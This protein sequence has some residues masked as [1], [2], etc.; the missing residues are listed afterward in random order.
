M[1][2]PT[3]SATIFLQQLGR[4][5]RQSRNKDVLTVLD[6]VGHQGKEFR[7]DLRYRRLLGRTRLELE[8]DI[9]EEFPYLPAGCHLE[10]DAVARDIVLDNIRHAL[11]TKWPQRVQELRALGDVDLRTYLDETGLERED[12]YR[13]NH[14]WTELRRGAG[15]PIAPA[16]EGEDKV[17][18]GIA[19]LLHLD[20]QAR[21]DAY[22][23]LLSAPQPPTIDQLDE[24]VR[25]QFEG[26]LLTV[27]NP[28]K[29][30]YETLDDAAAALWR[31]GELRHELLA[32]LPMLED[33]IVHLHQPLGLLQPVPLQVH[34]NYSREEILAAFGASGVTAPL[35]LQTGVYWHEPTQTDLFFV[36]LQ[37]TEKDYSPTTRYLD[38][39]ISDRLFHWESQ[40]T[41]SVASP[42]GQRYL[43]H[44]A[45]GSN[46]ALFVRPTKKDSNGRT[47]PYFS[48]GTATY[49]EHRSDR[50]IQITWELDH[51]LPG[52]I[53]SAYRA[54]VA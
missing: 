11:P 1:L 5:L 49:V 28:R 23:G 31:H 42:T 26:L 29:G 12:I 39:A 2:R 3:E 27:L 32:L 51:A 52:D 22:R 25:R 33:Q 44:R 8:R 46:V 41:T 43:T 37:K 19:R 38:Y 54:A 4:G 36:T 13:G 14:T 16:A 20:D 24:R 21:T 50:P 15:I 53:F 7:F 9:K 10:L 30:T 18:R 45:G 48:A 6:F 40:A 34:A 17:G 47:M 35:P